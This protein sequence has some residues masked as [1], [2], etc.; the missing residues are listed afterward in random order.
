MAD[1]EGFLRDTVEGK[2][3][4][5][6]VDFVEK[7]SAGGSGEGTL[8]VTVFDP[9]G[10]GDG[11]EVNVNEEVVA[12][13]LAMVPRKLKGWEAG[14]GEVI[15]GMKEKEEVAKGDRRGMWE[16]GDLTED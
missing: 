4:V 2:Q 11:K 13:G 16:Y 12:E 15:K 14:R 9:N 6:T 10:R 8:W 1:A 7:S 3:V 5:V